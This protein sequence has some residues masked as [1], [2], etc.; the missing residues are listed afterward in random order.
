MKSALELAM[1]RADAALDGEQVELTE[2]QKKELDQVKKVYSA[3][4]AE[5]EIALKGR[6]EK[7]ARESDRQ[8]FAEG[9]RQLEG[10]M[11]QKREQL[12]TER[13]A[14]LEAIRQQ[15]RA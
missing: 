14:K 1:E 2:A 12:F 3:R 13:D 5:Q 15:P 9:R 7:L 8:G 10:E 11:Q 6:L 4:W